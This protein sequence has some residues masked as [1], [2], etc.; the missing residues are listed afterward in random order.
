MSALI[1]SFETIEEV[2]D[3]LESIDQPEE[4]I[5]SAQAF[6]DE[7]P[8]AMAY[9]MARAEN[10]EDD[11]DAELLFYIGNVIFLSFKATSES[12]PSV[13]AE[14]IEKAEDTFLEQMRAIAEMSEDEAR[15]GFEPIFNAQPNMST[16][17]IGWV[18]QLSEDGVNEE[19]INALYSILQVLVNAFNTALNP[20]TT[21]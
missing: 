15:A 3:Q 8:A 4:A 10:M 9:L 18:E 2:S 13:S 1:V 11:E 21:E 12:L 6:A 16:Y 5:S 14:M 17:L 20:S 7:Q 19:S